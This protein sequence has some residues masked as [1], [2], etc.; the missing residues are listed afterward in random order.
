VILALDLAT[1]TG[2]ALGAPGAAPTAWSVNLGSGDHAR[3]YGR[4]LALTTKLL[5]EN[6]CDVL[7]YEAPIG[8]PKASAYLIGLAAIVQAAAAARGN[9]TLVK[10]DLGSVRKSFLGRAL[11]KA[12]FPG[13][14]DAAAKAAM[15][16]V[17]MHRCKILGWKVSDHDAADACACWDYARAQTSASAG[18]L[19]SPKGER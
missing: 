9:I 8:G 3:R 18:G 11:R 4:L 6:D 5:H 16:G 15:K 7:A 1:T 10:C 12:D 17:V 2:V 14:S 13:M 19:F